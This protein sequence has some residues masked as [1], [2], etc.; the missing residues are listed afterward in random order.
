MPTTPPKP[1]LDRSAALEVAGCLLGSSDP[2]DCYLGKELRALAERSDVATPAPGAGEE[3]APPVTVGVSRGDRRPRLHHCY[4]AAA[5]T[6]RSAGAVDEGIWAAYSAN[7]SANTLALLEHHTSEP[8][9]RRRRGA[10]TG[11]TR[12]AKA[13]CG[14]AGFAYS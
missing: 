8:G 7:T 1:R 6:M 10:I 2:G 3:A 13:A 11:A 12:S 5:A 4:H 9:S 14:G